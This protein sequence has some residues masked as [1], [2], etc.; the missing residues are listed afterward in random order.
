MSS[1]CAGQRNFQNVNCCQPSGTADRNQHKDPGASPS[2]EASNLQALRLSGVSGGVSASGWQRGRPNGKVLQRAGALRCG[3]EGISWA[4]GLLK[5]TGKPRRSLPHF[6]GR[7]EPRSCSKRRGECT[8]RPDLT[9][10]G[11][12]RL[13]G[14]QLRSFFAAPSFE[15]RDSPETLL[16][17]GDSF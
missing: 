3:E 10:S 11:S 13:R 4:K 9:R 16:A 8:F 2:P 17:S 1:P 14:T 12:D 5:E 7:F 15:A 6:L